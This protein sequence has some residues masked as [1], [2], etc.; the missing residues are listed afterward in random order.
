MAF[1]TA[2]VLLPQGEMPR[3]PGADFRTTLTNLAGTAVGRVGDTINQVG[4]NALRLQ[5]TIHT[6]LAVVNHGTHVA[7]STLGRAGRQGVQFITRGRASEKV[8]N[9]TET[10]I[11]VN[12]QQAMM[13]ALMIGTSM[14]L[15]Q[16][17]NGVLHLAQHG[18]QTG[19]EHIRNVR[20]IFD[21]FGDALQGGLH[22]EGSPPP[23]EVCANVGDGE[24]NTL[25]S[26]LKSALGRDPNYTELN[27]TIDN[28]GLRPKSPDDPVIVHMGERYCVNPTEPLGNAQSTINLGT[29]GGTENL[30]TSCV[31][32]TGPE[33][34]FPNFG[35]ALAH[36]LKTEFPSPEQIQE[37]MEPNGVSW[38]PNQAD[39][40]RFPLVSPGD[41]ICLPQSMQ[42][43]VENLGALD[44]TASVADNM[45]ATALV[46]GYESLS[47]PV[48]IGG[49]ILGLGTLAG[50]WAGRK[51]IATKFK[52]IRG[53][54]G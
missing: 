18:I 42:S 35:R 44:T 13:H 41:T 54:L 10:F 14:A 16:G 28:Y 37:A 23:P 19:S 3:F 2:D 27:V 17:V 31:D 51:S 43:A 32:I 46:G 33:G 39:P 5:N 45:R 12:A 9:A 53:G 11:T 52:S 29:S 21:N 22:Q 26:T 47:A 8:L 25:Y 7:A 40:N 50:L 15:A 20:N 34:N 4:A 1:A 49:G 36:L 38:Y 6:G 30:T 48:V 24:H